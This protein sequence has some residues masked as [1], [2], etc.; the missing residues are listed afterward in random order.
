MP[1]IENKDK[2]Y[3][4]LYRSIQ[5]HYLY[6]N[7]RTFTEFEAWVDMLL[8]ANHKDADILIGM[9]KVK[10]G[11]GE[12]LTSELKLS[13]RWMWGRDRVRNF[14]KLLMSDGM[15]SKKSSSKFTMITICNY[16]G[17]QNSPTAKQQQGNNKATTRQQQDD[18]NNNDNNDNN[19]NNENKER[20]SFEKFWNLYDKKTGRDKCET[21]WNNITNADREK[22]F[23]TLPKYLA[24]ITD[25]KYQKNPLTYLN[26]KYW[27]DEIVQNKKTE[28]VNPF[29]KL[30]HECEQGNI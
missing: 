16:D 23:E 27:N 17:Y 13:L 5:E 10:I 2:G 12:F 29:I 8:L 3:I 1:N 20:M 21:K 14:L 9:Q 30:L 6:P 22:I 11:R 18:T 7:H 25:K 26:G 28:F 19:D 15:I 24:T 4:S